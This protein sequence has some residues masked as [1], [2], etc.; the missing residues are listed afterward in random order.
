MILSQAHQALRDVSRA[1][2]PADL[3]K[4][5][6]CADWTVVQVLQHA[7]GDQQ[8]YAA[9]L[10]EGAMPSEDPFAPSGSP[11][12]APADFVEEAV[13]AAERAWSKVDPEAAEVPVPMP[14]NTMSAKVG[15]GACAL[16]AAV[17]AWDVAAAV[18]LPS[19]ITPE[20]ARELLPIARQVVIQPLRDYGAFGPV[21]D[22][23]GDDVAELLR[24]LGRDPEWKAL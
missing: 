2:A 21:L 16:D 23:A 13:A 6:P 24:F 11:A 8:A 1:V 4:P 17:H 12:T 15:A 3:A 7:A 10:G 9:F 14:P 20:M 19:P 22:G 18:G 5:T